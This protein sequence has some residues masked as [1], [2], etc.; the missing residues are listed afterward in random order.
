M[1]SFILTERERRLLRVWLE[2]GEEAEDLPR[3]FTWIRQS[4][5]RLTED[6]DLILKAIRE[7]K[8]RRR[9][10][11]RL[12]DRSELGLALLHAESGLTRLR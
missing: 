4:I 12:T 2:T 8:R 3:L 9:W 11:G 1:R 7:L 5:P 6:T 10:R